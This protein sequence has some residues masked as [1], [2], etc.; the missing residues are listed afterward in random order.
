MFLAKGDIYI[1]ILISL[2]VSKD[3][4]AWV[5]LTVGCLYKAHCACVCLY[6]QGA[7][8][9]MLGQD[10]RSLVTKRSWEIMQQTWPVM[11]QAQHS[12]KPSVLRLIDA[13]IEKLHKNVE[14]AEL[15]I[16]VTTHFMS[17]QRFLCFS[18]GWQL[19]LIL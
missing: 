3:W 7:L 4:E 17:Q 14:T 6:P 9:L 11:V 2:R 19:V 12:E 16:K 1:L 10:K 15:A 13:V 8:Y 18:H 5:V